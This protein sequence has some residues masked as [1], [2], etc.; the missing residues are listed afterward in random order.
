M[1][2]ALLGAISMRLFRLI[3]CVWITIGIPDLEKINALR[4]APGLRLGVVD[5]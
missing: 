4:M 3:N 5:K 2:N 1:V